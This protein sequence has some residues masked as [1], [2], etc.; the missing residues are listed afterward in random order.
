MI[1]FMISAVAQLPK[2]STMRTRILIAAAIF[3][4]ASGM[5]GQSA[6]AQELSFSY[7]VDITSNYISKGSTQTE[8]R[9]AI[10]PYLE[11]NYGKFYT[12]LWVSNVRFDGASDIEYDVSLGVRPRWGPVDFDIGFAQY[13]YRDDN[14]DYGEAI[15]KADWVVSD[16]VMVGLDYYREVYADENWFYLNAALAELPWGLTLSGGVGSDFGSRDLPSDKYALDV[17]LS[18]DL[19]EHSSADLRFYGGNYDDELIV[20]TLSFFN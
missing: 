18:R 2:S 19:S 17:G 15:I 9:P 10:Q 4:F 8:D 6:T 5:I 14:T 12:G 20:F 1:D 7:G 3:G 13:F 16:R 11:L